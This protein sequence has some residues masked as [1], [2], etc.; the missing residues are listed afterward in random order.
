LINGHKPAFE[1]F[2]ILLLINATSG[3]LCRFHFRWWI[4]FYFSDV[5]LSTRKQNTSQVIVQILSSQCL[6]FHYGDYKYNKNNHRAQ[7]HQLNSKK[8]SLI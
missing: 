6:T 1:R 4:E 7:S 8:S 5:G 2:S 3:H